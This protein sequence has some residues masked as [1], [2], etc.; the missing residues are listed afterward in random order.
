MSFGT[1]KVSHVPAGTCYVFYISIYILY[2]LT[3]T[4]LSVPQVRSGMDTCQLEIGLRGLR[5]VRG[6]L[7][8]ACECSIHRLINL[9]DTGMTIVNALS[10]W[11]IPSLVFK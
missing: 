6:H 1:H 11:L 5:A 3:R 10:S 9:V 8:V 4:D 7:P 2:V